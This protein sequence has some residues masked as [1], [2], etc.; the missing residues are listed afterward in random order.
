MKPQPAGSAFALAVRL[1]METDMSII[2]N[3]KEIA[4]L[5][6]KYNDQ[7]LYERIVALREEILALREEN[8]ALKESLKKAAD[9]AAIANE[10]IRVGNSYY[11]RT[12]AKHEHPFCLT[13]WDADRKLVSLIRT[14]RHDGTYI[15]CGIC[16]ARKR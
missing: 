10:I 4:A 1:R 12:D 13:C 8:I 5:V 15:K 11:K 6:K 16:A 3:A 9:D 7:D 2:D 14:E